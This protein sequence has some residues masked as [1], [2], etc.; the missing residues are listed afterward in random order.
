M[1][2]CWVK[3]KSAFQERGVWVKISSIFDGEMS[4]RLKEHAWKACKRESVSWVRIPLS[5]KIFLQKIGESG[6]R[7]L[8]FDLSGSERGSP[9]VIRPVRVRRR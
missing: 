1:T 4:E 6:V 7:T 5:P 9:K 8:G 3:S 2:I